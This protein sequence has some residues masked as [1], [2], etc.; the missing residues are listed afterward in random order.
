MEEAKIRIVVDATSIQAADGGAGATAA[1][2]PLRPR[3]VATPG[4][5]HPGEYREAFSK[6]EGGALRAFIRGLA[7]VRSLRPGEGVMRML[8]Q[9]IADRTPGSDIVR[10]A[11]SGAREQA[12]MMGE[13]KRRFE[14]SKKQRHEAVAE[15][16]REPGGH[17]LAE[18]A[19]QM[20][21]LRAVAGRTHAAG[22]PAVDAPIAAGD[23]AGQP[24][25]GLAAAE[26]A[27]IQAAENAAARGG[28]GAAATA[29]QAL[30][31]TR[32]LTIGGAA[33][34]GVGVGLA[35]AA[36][37]PRG[38]GFLEGAFGGERIAG[39]SDLADD[40][41]AGMAGAFG[42]A[43]GA[44]GA[45]DVAGAIGI[46]GAPGISRT[47][48]ARIFKGVIEVQMFEKMLEADIQRTKDR[49]AGQALLESAKALP[50]ILRATMGAVMR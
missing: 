4:P 5:D 27:G 33:A 35:A 32:A 44:K 28:V 10:R 50:E 9:R 2:R 43:G 24:A 14:E 22:A 37:I 26:R 13:A 7:G 1:T 20:L 31:T 45:A 21:A 30:L 19:R 12:E 29:G 46:V 34:A 41:A 39:L 42:L 38:V 8:T 23:V 48:R 16:H 6:D 17:P 36:A 18:T 3:Q 47:D 49:L 40:L 15:R 11:I 25:S